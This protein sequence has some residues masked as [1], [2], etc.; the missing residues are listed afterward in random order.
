MRTYL[1]S[2]IIVILFLAI[3]QATTAQW[4]GPAR[5]GQ[6][7][8]TGL[9]KTWP[10]EGPELLFK[11]SG[12]GEGF[13]SAVEHN[14]NI[15]VTGKIDTLDYI[16]SISPDGKINWQ[17]PYGRSWLKS[18][19]NSR[20]TP[21]LENMRAYLLSGT[22]RLVCIDAVQGKEIWS[23]D[24]D[25]DYEADWHRWGLA[26]SILVVDDLV[27]CCPAGKKT[28]MVAFNKISG[29]LAWKTESIGGQR[30]YVSPVL[31]E[32]NNIRQILG[33]TSKDVYGVDPGTGEIVWTYPYYLQGEKHEEDGAIIT[34]TPLWHED[35][36]FLT[37]GYNFPG[38][39]LK[40]SE[41]GKTVK[42]KWRNITLDNH[43]GHLVR[44]GDHI[45]GANWY[46]NRNGK[47][48]CLDWKTGEV[49]WVEG[50]H[51][52]GSIISAENML[53]IYEE[54]SGN[55][56]L[57]KAD[58]DEFLLSGTFQITEG[59]GPHWSHPSIY[60]GKLMIRHGDIIF[61]YNIKE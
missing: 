39:M 21:Y 2:V 38:V 43:H 19:S 6:F 32:Y 34:I 10:E 20:S 28:T 61:A 59:E 15:Y 4:R 56:G 8:E 37:A 58:P 47:W 36:I 11:L 50:W 13:S 33:M 55:V 25:K 45:Y 1:N 57:L 27:I 23:V 22:G 12:I 42:E 53:Y 16:S 7:P 14:G 51:T 48:V 9:L 31:Y 46:D 49:M 24:V 54:K 44:V 26:E 41:D 52:K 18:F 30:S 35:E 60:N 40:L 17:V 5:D 3:T 29:E